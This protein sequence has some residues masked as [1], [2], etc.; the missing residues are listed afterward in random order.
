LRTQFDESELRWRKTVAMSKRM[1]QAYRQTPWRIATQ[2]GVIFLIV[3]ILSAST[4]W[5]MVSVSIQA[6]SAGLEIQ[7][8]QSE[9][10]MLDRQ[11]AGLRT[12]YAMQTSAANMEKRAAELGF[13]PISPGDITYMVVPGYSGRESVIHA[14][15]PG[16]NT[17]PPL[18]KPIY[19]QSLW[20]WLLQGILAISEQP[21]GMVPR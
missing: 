5:V 18:I 3:A 1:V 4:L 16:A 6:A 19:T 2:R 17:E 12:E 10:E 11:I 7:T 20:E 9:R 8:L 13:R 15:P 21:E 14:P